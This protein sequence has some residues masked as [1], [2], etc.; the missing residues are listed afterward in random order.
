MK[1]EFRYGVVGVGGIGSA[2]AYWLSRRDTGREVLALERFEL[3]HDRGAS[4]DRGRV[5]RYFYHRPEYVRMAPSSF[6]AWSELEQDMDAQL[7]HMTG[8][9]TLHPDGTAIPAEDYT[10]ALD[11]CGVGY[12]RLSGSE[13]RR[14]WPQF[15]IADN[16]IGIV[17]DDTGIVRADLANDAHVAGARRNGATV[18]G[19]ARVREVVPR[20]DAYELRTDDATYRCEK[21]VI[22]ADAWTNEFLELLG[23]PINL[24]VTQEQV[25]YYAAPDAFAIG[26]FPVWAWMDAET[27]YGLPA[28]ADVPA[29]AS[30]DSGGPRVDP[31][32]RSFVRDEPYQGRLERFLERRLPDLLGDLLWTKTCLYTMTPDRDFVIDRVPDHPGIVV[33]QGAAHAFK[34]ASLIGRIAADLAMEKEPEVDIAAFSMRRSALSAPDPDF[35]LLLRRSE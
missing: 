7:V 22:A 9:I 13:I 28:F 11:A 6:A 29:K 26:A 23:S 24:T 18:L 10:A 31:D 25:A 8:G 19:G 34:F 12:E 35:E 17:Q 4:R 20:G 15:R 1:S 5:I 16:V 14:R 2:A 33:C 21:V 32:E 30:M 27:F 3:D